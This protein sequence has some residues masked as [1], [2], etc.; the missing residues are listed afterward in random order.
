[1]KRRL[2]LSLAIATIIICAGNGRAAEEGWV[3]LF[4]GKG[5]NGWTVVAFVTRSIRRVTE[6]REG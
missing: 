2:L 3:S 6:R 5:L 4:D 1:M